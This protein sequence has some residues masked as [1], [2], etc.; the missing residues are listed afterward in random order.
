MNDA[1]PVSEGGTGQWWGFLL[2]ACLDFWLVSGGSQHSP[3][4]VV[5]MLWEGL[6]PKNVFFPHPF[7]HP[8]RGRPHQGFLD[9]EVSWT[10]NVKMPWV[11]RKCFQGLKILQRFWSGNGSCCLP[12]QHFVL[13]ALLWAGSALWVQGYVWDL[14]ETGRQPSRAGSARGAA[15]QADV[16]L[17]WGSAGLRQDVPILQ[18][19]ESIE[20]SNRLGMSESSYEFLGKRIWQWQDVLWAGSAL[21]VG[22]TPR[23]PMGSA[24][25]P[26][27]AGQLGCMSRCL[28]RTVPGPVP[29]LKETTALLEHCFS[30]CWMRG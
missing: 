27:L 18:R 4:P 28:F 8:H 7:P 14:A 21:W 26:V 19:A 6:M 1:F 15:F 5:Q 29:A 11:G 10:I 3:E 12:K 20:I 9:C 13:L 23:C 24:G 22:D 16:L 2:P 17:A 30:C 25:S